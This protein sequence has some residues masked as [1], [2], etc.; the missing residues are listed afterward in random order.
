M[1]G[2][3]EDDSQKNAIQ[4]GMLPDF[5]DS[6]VSGP[7]CGGKE[8][9]ES[10]PT[11]RELVRL[12]IEHPRS[13]IPDE[14]LRTEIRDEDNQCQTPQPHWQAVNDEIMDELMSQ[15]DREWRTNKWVE[16]TIQPQ[17]S[18]SIREQEERTDYGEPMIRANHGASDQEAHRKVWKQ[19]QRLTKMASQ[20]SH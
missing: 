16:K 14:A 1:P 11:Q 3:L 13:E 20:E 9:P 17:D 6:E 4:P 2:Q 5:P 18:I 10:R 19:A 8:R 15:D 12:E 7:L